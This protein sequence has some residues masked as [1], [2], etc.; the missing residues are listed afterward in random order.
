[1]DKAAIDDPV[2]P[3]HGCIWR[4]AFHNNGSAKGMVRIKWSQSSLIR[5]LHKWSQ[6][7]D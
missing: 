4:K 5:F 1:M 3:P 7:G 6:F 2:A